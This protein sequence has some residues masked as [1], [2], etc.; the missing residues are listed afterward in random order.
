MNDD[1]REAHRIDSP[2]SPSTFEKPCSMSLE[3]GKGGS[4]DLFRSAH[5]ETM[6]AAW[7]TFPGRNE[8]T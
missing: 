1:K 4:L 5:E 7:Y 8:E 2:F 6:N 3:C